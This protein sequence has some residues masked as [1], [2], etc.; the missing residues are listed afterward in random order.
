VVEELQTVIRDAPDNLVAQRLVAE[1]SLMLGRVTDALGAY[2][3]LLYFS[4][5]DQET[6]KVVKELESQAYEKG[7]LV[8]RTDPKPSTAFSEAPASDAIAGDPAL[9]RLRW[10]KDIERLQGILQRVERYRVKA[11]LTPS[12]TRDRNSSTS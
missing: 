2:K 7:A 6:A 10:V 12:R 11:E 4:P 9:K 8:L 1:S 3:M 5:N